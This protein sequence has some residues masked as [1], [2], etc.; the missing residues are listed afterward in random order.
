MLDG[1]VK[2]HRSLL[3]SAVFQDPACLRV[4]VW[5]LLRASYRDRQFLHGNTVMALEPGQFVTGRF[6]GAQECGLPPSTFYRKL[7]TLETLGNIKQDSSSK[8]TVITIVNWDTYQISGSDN[9]QQLSSKRTPTEHKQE[10]K[11]GEEKSVDLFGLPVDVPPARK[12]KIGNPKPD[13]ILLLLPDDMKTLSKPHV[14]AYCR[15][16]AEIKEGFS[17]ET[18]RIMI[19]QQTADRVVYAMRLLVSKGWR[20]LERAL[21]WMKDHADDQKIREHYQRFAKGLHEQ[22]P[23]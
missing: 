18:L 7:Q 6:T 12:T 5:C 22:R 21:G 11:E 16:C 19:D 4:W 15:H 1:W 23:S 17:F 8:W 13:E 2:L 14:E 20:K 9:E 3:G 10:G